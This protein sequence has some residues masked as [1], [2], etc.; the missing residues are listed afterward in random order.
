MDYKILSSLAKVFYDEICGDY[1][2]TSINCL[3]NERVSFQ[4]AVKTEQDENIYMQVSS[5]G[6]SVNVY[7][8]KNM[9]SSYAAPDKADRDDYY[10][11]DGIPGEYPDLLMPLSDNHISVEGGKWQ[12]FWFEFDSHGVPAGNHDIEIDIVGATK[13]SVT[14]PVEIF[15]TALPEQT[16]ICTHWFHSD[17]LAEYYNVDVFSDE[18]WRITE[19][20]MRTAA[21]HGV[22]MILTPLFTPPLDTEVGGERLTV[23]LVDVTRQGDCYVFGFDN[24]K[25]WIA[26]AEKAGMKYFEMSHLFTQWGA[27]HAPKIMAETENGYERIFG[28][29]TDASGK[30]YVSFLKQLA[31][32][33][34]SVINSLGIHDRC[35][36]HTSDEPSVKDYFNYMKASK[37]MQE[38]FGEFKITDALSDYLYYKLGAVRHPIPSTD[39]IEKFAYKVP[40]LWTYYCCAQ[41]GGTRPNRFFAMPSLRNRI[42]GY[43]MFKYDIKGFLHWGY[44]FYNTQYSLKSVD[45]F[46]ETDAGRAFP[47]GDSFVV[48]PA[49]DGT[50][51]VSLRFKV[52]FEA[53][54]DYEALRFL[55]SKI[56]RES[57]LKILEDGID[58]PIECWEYPHSEEWLVNKRREINMKIAEEQ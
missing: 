42:L 11:K 52:F 13:H 29:E 17:C 37:I 14:M 34:I 24:L 57:T 27:K 20:F 19:N 8:V 9:P 1:E 25:K 30:E 33:L 38:L 58:K 22:N 39:K 54:E 36:F 51:Y 53:V 49:P 23:Q 5:L 48:Y 26:V 45:P 47:S 55:E 43:I 16:L 3:G 32:E 50:P 56:G 7:Y 40:D 35:I 18:Y 15:N 6:E 31:P 44:N 10:L 41:C 4:I 12:S 28:W 46:K 2:I 21:E